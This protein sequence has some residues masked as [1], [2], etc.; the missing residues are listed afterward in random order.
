MI[1]DGVSTCLGLE[2]FCFEGDDLWA[3][4]DADLIALARKEIAAVG[5]MD[6]DDITD[7]HVVRQKKAYPVYDERYGAN[8]AA[9]RDELVAAYP[10][11]HL[12]GRNG[13]HK[14]NNQDHAMMT[15]ML[16]AENIVAGSRFTMC[17]GSTRTPNIWRPARAARA[18]RWRA[19]ASC[20]AAPLDHPRRRLAMN[21]LG[22]ES[23]S[24]G[25]GLAAVLL[26]GIAFGVA[27]R[28]PSGGLTDLLLITQDLGVML[29][30]V[31]VAAALRLAPGLASSIAGAMTALG[32]AGVFRSADRRRR[33]IAVLVWPRSRS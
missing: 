16:T 14:Y 28:V 27:A 18:K 29:G 21:M 26:A 32:S 24:F 30:V 33:P 31:A 6:I 8:V 12:I 13:M 9:V 2:Y 22:R 25:S 7:G 15:G 11:L 4:T 5:L 3:M 10:S 23:R 1:P 20:R 19:N 17:G